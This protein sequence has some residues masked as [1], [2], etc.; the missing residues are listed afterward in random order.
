VNLLD[1]IQVAFGALAALAGVAL[2]QSLLLWPLGHRSA[3]Q[4]TWKMFGH[5]SDPRW[6]EV[7]LYHGVFGLCVKLMRPAAVVC[8]VTWPLVV[9]LVTAAD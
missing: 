2:L 8:A 4:V 5:P 7:R 3:K 1:Y 9:V 6:R